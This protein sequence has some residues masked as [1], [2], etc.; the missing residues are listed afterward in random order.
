M[1]IDIQTAARAGDVLAAADSQIAAALAREEA[2]QRGTL[3]MIASENF[4]SAAVLEVVG[5]VLTNKYA[6]GY[7]GKRYYGGCEFIDEIETLA[8]ERARALFGAEHANVQPHSGAQANMGVYMGVI[9]PGDTVMGMKLDQGGHLTHGSNVNFSGKL[10]RFVS[11]GVERERETIDYEQMA[12]LAREHRP[13]VIVVGATAY[14]R[15]IDFPHAR[16]IADEVGALLM[17]DM[18]H[19]AGLVAAGVHPTPVGHAQLI[20]SSTHKTLRGPRGGLILCDA[21]YAR[22]IDRGVFPGAQGGPLMH[23]VAGK[24]VAFLEAATPEFSAYARQIV[25]NAQ[26]LAETLLD[27]GLRIVS[28][29]TD[30]HLLLVDV[31]PKGLNGQQAEDALARCGIIV[32]KNAIPYDT[33]PPAVA[34]GIRIGTPALTSRGLGA[35]ELRRVGVLIAEVLDAPDDA[36]V[37]RRASEAVQALCAAYPAPGVPAA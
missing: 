33:L 10:Y 1:T 24:A 36:A 31:T 34:S 8:I 30:N 15:V 26:A 25:E 4:T 28:G 17:A 16:A 20:T 23:V 22:S 37:Q 11:Y 27:A 21:A 32:N 3:E 13:K 18:A 9:K 35:Q 2:R 29:G 7:P 12:A 19:I 6:E 14:P 5:S